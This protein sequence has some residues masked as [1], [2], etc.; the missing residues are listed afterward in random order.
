MIE[1][2]VLKVYKTEPMSFSIGP[3][4]VLKMKKS[5]PQVEE[6]A[7]KTRNPRKSAQM[8]QPNRLNDVGDKKLIIQN[9][10]LASAT[11][12]IKKKCRKIHKSQV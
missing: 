5:L 11:Q 1:W 12:K 8:A 10:R 6:D 3:K 4:P 2:S 9:D 7:K